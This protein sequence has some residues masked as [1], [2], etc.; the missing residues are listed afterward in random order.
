MSE[1]KPLTVGESQ[2][3][4]WKPQTSQS[5]VH[6]RIKATLLTAKN[7]VEMLMDLEP[8]GEGTEEEEEYRQ[9]EQQQS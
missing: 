9:T 8:V 6:I 7:F 1:W 2:R 4:A 3:P 5:T